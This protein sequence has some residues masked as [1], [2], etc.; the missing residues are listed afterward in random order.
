[1]LGS[2]RKRRGRAERAEPRFDAAPGALDLRLTAD[3][4]AAAPRGRRPR[5]G[6]AKTRGGSEPPVSAPAKATRSRSSGDGGGGNRRRGNGGGSGGGR[7][8][9]VRRILTW[10]A[11]VAIWV[12]VGVAG[13]VAYEAARLPSI[14]S[15]QIPP[16]PPSVTILASD[17]SLLAHRGEG[18][19]AVK[20]SELPP[21]LPK[22]FVAIE[23]RRFY[24][25][26][27]VDPIGLVRAL[28]QDVRTGGVVEGG[29]TIT[30]QLAKN[31]FLTPERSLER[32]IQEAILAVWLE[33]KFT[34]REIL[35]LYLNRVYFGDGAYGVEAAA[36]RYFGTSARH[37]TLAEAAILAGLVKAPSRLAPT[38]N[39]KAAEARGELV[40]GAMADAGF[41]TGREAKTA[42]AAPMA[43]AAPR[44]EGAAG[45]VADWVMDQLDDL[46]GEYH[47]DLVVDTTIDPVLQAEGEE[48][49]VRTL[50]QEGAKYGVRQGALVSLGMD[51]AVR[52]LVGGRSYAQSQ[53]DR[54]VTAR[55]Q[56]GSAF[57]PFV[58]LAALERGD[59]PDT[60]VR[61]APIALKGWRPENADHRYRGPVPLTEALALSLNTVSVRLTLDVGPRAVVAT[62]RR[63]GI[64]SPLTADPSIAL[65]TSEVSPLEM[66]G[67]YAS[68]ANGGYGI[69][70]YVVSRVRTTG[71]RAHALYAHQGSGLGRVIDPDEVGM[72]NYMLSQTLAIGTARRASAGGW[73]AA[74][75]TGT[76]QDFRDA[77]FVG[78]TAR[79]VTAVWVG[80]DDDSPTRHASGSNVPVAIWSTFMT[81]AHRGLTPMALP[82]DWHSTLVAEGGAGPGAAV[83]NSG[84]PLP[85]DRGAPTIVRAPL[86]FIRHLF[87]G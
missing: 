11:V 26:F 6:A 3:D 45:Y 24:S 36:Q 9:W 85:P 75:K 51:G 74:G 44:S 15:L 49:V 2:G 27:G 10:A 14:Q 57:K 17:G 47:S 77:W 48:A 50:D 67:A 1:M 8:G 60:V 71:A 83:V 12:V 33:H 34:K 80:N 76:S 25:H 21:Y 23:D 28:Y 43:V 63:L 55:R 13:I 52:A 20:L 61:D 31:L 53:Y 19:A 70:P 40:L 82:G 73:P 58:Y 56:P 69:I 35:A 79:L 4:R 18:G 66:A 65:G 29:S 7:R 78:Y 46:V 5:A 39:L 37:V 41:I 86:A 72:M 32:K 16:R 68:F 59:T 38:H 62:A 64:V 81:A 84:Y 87:G 54:A 42:M 30:Q 22:A